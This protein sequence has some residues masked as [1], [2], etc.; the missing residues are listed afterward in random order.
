MTFQTRNW[1]HSSK[2]Q[3]EEPLLLK[4][5][6]TERQR[7]R[8][9]N[10]LNYY[11]PYKKQLEFH[12]AGATHRERLLMAGNQLGKTLAG[13]FEA[14][15]HATGRYPDDWKGATRCR[16]SWWDVPAR[17]RIGLCSWHSRAAGHD[18]GQACLGWSL[19]HR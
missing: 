12:E 19:N 11:R 2:L 9:E 17:K 4:T 5:L 7:R 16:K 8:T 13:G 15:M 6:E 10:R 1:M 18:Q 3:E 14:A